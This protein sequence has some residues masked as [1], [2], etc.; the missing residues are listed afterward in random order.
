VARLV[1]ESISVVAAYSEPDRGDEVRHF[2]N[3]RATASA[4]RRYPLPCVDLCPAAD[5][6]DDHRP[7]AV[8]PGTDE[9]SDSIATGAPFFRFM[10][11]AV[12][13][14]FQAR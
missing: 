6:A 12:F 2:G 8:D 4:M 13:S 5:K 1:Q 11:S 10:K 7:A 9:N 3:A 14:R